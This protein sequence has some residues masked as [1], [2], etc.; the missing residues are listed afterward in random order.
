MKDTSEA[1]L[2]VNS[3]LYPSERITFNGTLM[4]EDPV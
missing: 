1:D 4:V 3:E 2:Q